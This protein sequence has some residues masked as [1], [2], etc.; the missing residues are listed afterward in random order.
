MKGE[1]L[2]YNTAPLHHQHSLA[3]MDSGHASQYTMSTSTHTSRGPMRATVRPRGIPDNIPSTLCSVSTESTLTST[4]STSGRHHSRHHSMTSSSQHRTSMQ[5]HKRT[6][7]V[8]G[9]ANIVTASGNSSCPSAISCSQSRKPPVKHHTERSLLEMKKHSNSCGELGRM[10]SSENKENFPT[11][12]SSVTTATTMKKAQSD[13]DTHYRQRS[14]VSKPFRDKTNVVNAEKKS[15]S[16]AGSGSLSRK[17]PMKSSASLK[18]L[19]PPLNAARLR[20]IQQQTRSAIVC[21]A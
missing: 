21:R 9:L 2:P 5:Q 14:T 3:S 12:R 8:E 19:V 18:E 4:P 16:S 13:L 10:R 15:E 7:S 11:E 20:P 6:C 17:E 1:H